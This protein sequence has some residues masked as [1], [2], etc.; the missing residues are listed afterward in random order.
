MMPSSKAMKRHASKDRSFELKR[1]ALQCSYSNAR[2]QQTASWLSDISRC[3]QIKR[4]T[5]ST[6]LCYLCQATLLK[7]E[8]TNACISYKTTREA[9]RRSE[10]SKAVSAGVPDSNDAIKMHT[11]P[12]LTCHC[13]RHSEAKSERAAMVL[14]RSTHVRGK[15]ERTAPSAVGEWV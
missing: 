12:C 9:R 3:S 6:V 7:Q 14:C 2:Y 5:H 10:V 1:L 4:C 15:K 8:R 11:L 13:T